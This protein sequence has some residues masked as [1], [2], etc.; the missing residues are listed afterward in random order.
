MRGGKDPAKIYI[1]RGGE[2]D[3]R[4]T[5]K[6][7]KESGRVVVSNANWRIFLGHT[8]FALPIIAGS[9]AFDEAG[10]PSFRAMFPYFARRRNSG[11][12]LQPVTTIEATT[13]RRLAGKSLLPFGARLGNSLEFQ[14]VRGRERTLEELKKAAQGNV[15]GQVI[16]TVAELRPQVTIAET[17]SQKLREQLANFRSSLLPGSVPARRSCE[18][19]NADSGTRGRVTSRDDSTLGAALAV[20]MPPERTDLQQMYNAVGVSCLDSSSAL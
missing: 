1:L 4:L 14:K 12:F 8:I 17:K 11:G 16:G 3:I 18:D 6:I 7:D 13:T 20:E 5:K 15:L 2:D 10:A 19:R 9:S